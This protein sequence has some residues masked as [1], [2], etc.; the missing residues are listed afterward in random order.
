MIDLHS[1][2]ELYIV[3]NKYFLTV[4]RIVSSD[5]LSYSLLLTCEA[6]QIEVLLPCH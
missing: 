5:F 6:T 2:A 3:A 4:S 1:V